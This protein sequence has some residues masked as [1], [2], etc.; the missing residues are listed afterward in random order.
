[1]FY[2]I[3]LFIVF[4]SAHPIHHVE[5]NDCDSYFV[6]R[7]DEM[8]QDARVEGDAGTIVQMEG[9][10]EDASWTCY[11]DSNHTSRKDRVN[12]AKNSIFL[13]NDLVKNFDSFHNPRGKESSKYFAN[14][15][16][17]YYTIVLH[18][19]KIP[20]FLQNEAKNYLKSY[21][22]KSLKSPIKDA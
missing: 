8:L 11:L 10:E 17:E 16:K 18:D 20:K 15:L 4:A 19:R 2:F 14:L 21:N 3:F 1:M 5:T 13:L 12:Y 6:M 9:L 22:L 7:T